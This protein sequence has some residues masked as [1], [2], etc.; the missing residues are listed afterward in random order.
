MTKDAII[1]LL[2][3][4]HMELLR[5]FNQQDEEK[6]E[7]GPEKKW[8]TGQHVLHLVESLQLLNKALKYP[9]FLLKYKF[10]TSNREVRTYDETV[11][12]K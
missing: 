4:K 9:K 1:D 7:I 8:T 5:W 2:E 6:W 10:G 3:D 12:V 11:K